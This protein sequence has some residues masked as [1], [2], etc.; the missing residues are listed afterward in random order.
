M[1]GLLLDTHMLIWLAL[2]DTT[3]MP[4]TAAKLI[5]DPQTMFL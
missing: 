4:Q 1:A 2:G 5:Q 3:Q